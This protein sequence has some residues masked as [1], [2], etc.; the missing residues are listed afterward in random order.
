MIV[1]SYTHKVGC[2]FCLSQ[3]QSSTYVLLWSNHNSV[4]NHKRKI[5]HAQPMYSLGLELESDSSPS[6]SEYQDSA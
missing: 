6:G 3:Q 5:R 2:K 1:T 4:Q